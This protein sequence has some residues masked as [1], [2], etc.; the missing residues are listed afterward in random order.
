M[1]IPL[2]LSLAAVAIVVTVA[3]LSVQDPPRVIDGDTFIFQ[4]ERIRLWGVNAPERDLASKQALKEILLYPSSARPTI[5]ITCTSRGSDRWH[6]TVAQCFANGQ[7]VG[8][9]LVLRGH[10]RDVP[11]FSNG[12]YAPDEAVARK[13]FRGIWATGQQTP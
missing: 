3:A 8:K 10:A 5:H 4:G 2:N 1:N 12:Y 6:R 13:E 7:D 9:E 11:R